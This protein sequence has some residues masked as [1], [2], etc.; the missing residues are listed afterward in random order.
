M[1]KNVDFSGRPF[2]FIGIGGIGMSALAYILAKRNL[3]TYGSDLKSSHITKRLQAI[4]THIF[5]CQD[6]KNLELF[7]QISQQKNLS[8]S[9]DSNLNFSSINLRLNAEALMTKKHN[10]R[11]EDNQEISEL[12]QV[13]CSTAINKTNSEYKAA[14]ALGC[15]ILHRSDLLA[16]L[17]QDYQSIAVA[18]THGK[19]TT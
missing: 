9:N 11:M 7:Q 8:P 10:G 16:A 2:H 18:G 12:P 6:A 1:S 5:W 3:P 13:I 17:I 4:G 14:I 15:P 19:T